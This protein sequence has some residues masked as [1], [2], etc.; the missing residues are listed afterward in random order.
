MIERKIVH[1][2]SHNVVMTKLSN[3]KNSIA[4]GKGIGFQ[5]KPGMEVNENDIKQEF[6]LHTTEVL[7]HY[8][9]ILY[10]VDFK[11]I[12]VV[13]EVIAFAQSHLEGDFSET[14]H[15]ALVDHINLAIERCK[16]GLV[17]SNPFMFEIQHLYRDEYRVAE[18]AI[19]YLNDQLDVKL[20][21]DEVAFLA[22]HFHGARSGGKGNKSVAEL[23]MISRVL[24]NGKHVGIDFDESLSTVLF[25]G[26][27]K[28]LIDRVR[29]GRTL[30]NPLLV[31]IRE[32]YEEAYE[33]AIILAGWIA[34]GLEKAVPPE[35][36]GFLTM[37]LERLVQRKNV[38]I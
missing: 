36:I 11:I 5:K 25:I 10:A 34:E 29:A 6:L 35:E 21:Q 23:K 27:L 2:L 17:I 4:F 31:Q 38:S 7:E 16:R 13:E 33:K 15:S 1:V 28:G 3:G 19:D 12:G 26:H 24:E 8:E 32:E 22:M 20:P 9:Q 30:N 14:I 37:H 18:R